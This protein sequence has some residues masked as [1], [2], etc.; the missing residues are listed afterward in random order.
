MTGI[1]S[2]FITFLHVQYVY[3]LLF[4]IASHVFWFWSSL[5]HLP[6]LE[7]ALIGQSK[8]LMW[9]CKVCLS[10]VIILCC[11]VSNSSVIMVNNCL[12]DSFFCETMTA[13]DQLFQLERIIRLIITHID[14]NIENLHNNPSTPTTLLI[15]CNV[16]FSDLLNSVYC[17]FWIRYNVIWT[18]VLAYKQ[19]CPLFWTHWPRLPCDLSRSACIK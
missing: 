4:H 3:N 19:M 9:N 12:C 5:S 8:V 18:F 13:I 2:C 7:V 16:R 15:E 17:E 14:L 6:P 10:I 11:L 1:P